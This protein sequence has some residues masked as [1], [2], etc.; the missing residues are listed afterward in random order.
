MPKTSSAA[1]KSSA[2]EG[3][4]Y[5]VPSSSS[6]KRADSVPLP[7]SVGE[8]FVLCVSTNAANSGAG[9]FAP[10][11]TRALAARDC[12]PSRNPAF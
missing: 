11:Y 9:R 4:A 6:T 10:E 3:F 2:C 12:L 1:R 8:Q 7:A 5:V